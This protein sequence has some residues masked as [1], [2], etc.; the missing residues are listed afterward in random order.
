VLG[1]QWFIATRHP[2]AQADTASPPA[3]STV[4]PEK[5]PLSTGK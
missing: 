2:A 4:S 1:S 5:A 3:A